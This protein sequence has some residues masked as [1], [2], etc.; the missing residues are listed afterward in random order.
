VPPCSSVAMLRNLRS[1]GGPRKHSRSFNSRA[2]AC[3]GRCPRTRL[4]FL[5]RERQETRNRT[6]T[7]SAARVEV[8]R[9][10]SRL[11]Q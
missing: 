8:P 10:R 2:R 1:R 6:R 3:A 11:S 7:A 9:G 5:R 4:R